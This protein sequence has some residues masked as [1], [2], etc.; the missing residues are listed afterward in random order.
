MVHK[1]FTVARYRIADVFTNSALSSSSRT[2]AHLRSLE[3]LTKIRTKLLGLMQSPLHESIVYPTTDSREKFELVPRYA[4][5]F[6]FDRI[7]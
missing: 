3:L 7:C 1:F 5:G 2:L 6:S 4:S